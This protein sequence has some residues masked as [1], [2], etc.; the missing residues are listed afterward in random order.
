MNH[1]SMFLLFLT[2]A[3]AQTNQET[4]YTPTTM[5]IAFGSC[6]RPHEPTNIWP[7][8]G[9][10]APDTWVWLGDNV[11]LD[12]KKR[13]FYGLDEA[14]LIYK[15][16]QEKPEYVNAMSKVRNVIGTWDDHDLGKNNMGADFKHKN[17]TKK[18]L[19]NF[20][21]MSESDLA[22]KNGGVFH[23][24]IVETNGKKTAFV[25]TDAR[26]YK[27][28]TQLLGEP[29]WEWLKNIFLHESYD[30]IVLASSIQVTADWGSSFPILKRL[31]RWGDYPEE[32]SRLIEYIEKSNS[33]TVILSGDVH[34][35][36]IATMGPGC[37]LNG[38][39]LNKKLV[40]ATSSG[41]THSVMNHIQP[42][43]LWKKIVNRVDITPLAFSMER[44]RDILLDK[45][46]GTID[47]SFLPHGVSVNI[48]IHDETRPRLN[49]VHTFH[50][51]VL[52]GGNGTASSGLPWCP[53]EATHPAA[54]PW[55]SM[56]I[57]VLVYLFVN[58]VLFLLPVL[59]CFKLLWRAV[60]MP[61]EKEE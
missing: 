42:S 8:V 9:S 44:R 47:V 23:K 50:S 21:K 54:H 36:D 41:I 38:V 28:E 60:K 2:H 19:L 49:F 56:A 33:P 53:V 32:L 25:M 55:A 17:D 4:K 24:K 7:R 30:L 12:D 51:S 31:E 48:S 6:N 35:G 18:L 16:M 14:K 58:S 27:T 40:E 34:Y 20:L 1:L 46:W 52:G 37:V 10:Y 59:L 39:E 3:A 5:K 26:W 13:G 61:K 43:F 45:N 29:Q 15:S 11:Y 57:G 22:I